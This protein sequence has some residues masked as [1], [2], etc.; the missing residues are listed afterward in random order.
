MKIN[1]SGHQQV[2]GSERVKPVYNV[3]SF[4]SKYSVKTSRLF[5]NTIKSSSVVIRKVIKAQNLDY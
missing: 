2:P 3:K 5:C 4:S 1:T